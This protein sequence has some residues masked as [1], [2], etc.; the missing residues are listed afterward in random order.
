MSHSETTTLSFILEINFDVSWRV[1]L[2][3]SVVTSGK[4]TA[5]K[6]VMGSLSLPVQL[7]SVVFD[8]LLLEVARLVESQMPRLSL[9]Q[10]LE[11]GSNG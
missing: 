1:S 9:V 2:T 7:P 8:I 3:E 5:G 10:S 4:Q 11:G 6:L